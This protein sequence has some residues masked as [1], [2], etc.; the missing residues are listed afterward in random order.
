MKRKC[1][2]AKAVAPSVLCVFLVAN[3]QMLGAPFQMLGEQDFAD[4][5]IVSEP[6]FNHAQVNESLPTTGI[7]VSPGVITYFH[8]GLDP[9]VA[10]IL[11]FSLWDLDSREPGNQVVDFRLDNIPQPIGGF[12]S[13]EP[14]M[15]IK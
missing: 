10:G 1:R 14:D 5:A 9:G 15:G 8:Y 11:T 6:D 12:E 13:N 7:G 3:R 2:L 4:G